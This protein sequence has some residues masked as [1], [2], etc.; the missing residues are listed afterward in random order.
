MNTVTIKKYIEVALCLCIILAVAVRHQGFLRYA[1]QY[2]V[3]SNLRV[4]SLVY[5]L[6]FV[7][8]VGIAFLF[9]FYGLGKRLL[10]ALCGTGTDT[11]Y[12]K[13]FS[14][15]LG[16]GMFNLIVF[17]MGIAG[18][19][20]PSLIL[21]LLVSGIAVEA[22]SVRKIVL[23]FAAGA[24]ALRSWDPVMVLLGA[25][26]LAYSLVPALSPP[27]SWDALAYHLPIP[28]Q[29]AES[30]GISFIPSMAMKQCSIGME[31]LSCAALSLGIDVL[32][33]LFSYMTEILVVY[34]LFLF[35]KR[36]FTEYA[37]RLS[38][39][40]MAVMPVA[41][42]I[43]GVTN[44]DFS[45]CLF[46]L[47]AIVSFFE[48]RAEK[49]SR[50][51]YLMAAFCGFALTAK[52][53]GFITLTWLLLSLLYVS[54]RDKEPVPKKTILTAAVILI[55]FG[56]SAYIKNYMWT[57]NPVFP[58]LS[59]I[60]RGSDASALSVIKKYN[61]EVRMTEGVEA[62]VLNFVRLPYYLIVR[63]ERYQYQPHY[64]V[65]SAAM[66]F[67]LRIL[68]VRRRFA[69][70]ELHLMLFILYFAVIWFFGGT[71]LWRFALLVLPF[72]IFL[73]VKWSLDHD[74]RKLQ[75][76]SLMLLS[77]NAAPLLAWNVNNQLFGMLSLPSLEKKNA[78][79][80]DQYLD[81]SLDHYNVYKYINETLAPDAKILLF[82]EI[83]GYYLERPYMWGDPLNQSAIV[84]EQ[85]PNALALFNHLKKYGIT[86]I[87]INEN[88]YAP[89]PYYYDSAVM[90]LMYGLI[91][92]YGHE[93]YQHNRV[94]V[95][96]I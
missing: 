12:E 27:T 21:L 91:A 39:V 8:G 62:T 14:V 60:F 6:L 83:R 18:L 56:S 49:R 19:I 69:F 67:L 66:I 48:Y 9:C 20:Y 1:L 47:L 92:G 37:A 63:Q 45:V 73:V 89:S 26:G 29:Y 94:K 96:Q 17:I 43:G 93:L 54:I 78:G 24:N 95:Y 74:T 28:K 52:M 70:Q 51:L 42:G 30:H 7:P 16:L 87:V 3:L 23:D 61:L 79:A 38:V 50:W 44:N 22:R 36:N 58:Y 5:N 57:N 65:M 13:L 90:T 75:V 64:F 85:F 81:K 41:L 33:Q 76:V 2:D 40:V 46:S 84:Y 31:M 34:A 86:H 11:C 88:I 25:L 71:Q 72:M 10:T 53:T 77:V 59:G 15:S 4:A 35:V 55:L 32:P 80:R 82:R 68:L